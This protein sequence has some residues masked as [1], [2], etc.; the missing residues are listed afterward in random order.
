MN[1]PLSPLTVP[2]PRYLLESDSSDEEGQGSYLAS[3]LKTASASVPSFSI[4]W[5]DAESSFDTVVV[6]TGQAGKYIAR[7]AGASSPCLTMLMDSEVMGHGYRC[8]Q[9]L[10]IV[11]DDEIDE[12]QPAVWEGANALLGV[13]ANK[14]I[15]A[16]AYLPSIYI[17]DES[18]SP[19]KFH[20]IRYLHI[21]GPDPQLDKSG[22]RRLSPPNFVTGLPA[23]ISSIASHPSSP[24]PLSSPVTTLLLPLPLSSIPSDHFNASIAAISSSLGKSLTSHAKASGSRWTEE[25][26][27]Q[28]SAPGMGGKRKWRDNKQA[29]REDISVMY[30]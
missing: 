7:K 9:D 2:P 8:A 21:R 20:P 17:T 15:I 28:F 13:Q 5:A 6:S 12:A 27:E 24:L 18:E 26:D 30:M 29:A 11:L 25:H 1:D 4:Q 10:I 23:S 14:W 19:Y 22:A 3:R 16:A